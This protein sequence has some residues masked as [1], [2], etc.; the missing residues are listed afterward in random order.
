MKLFWIFIILL[1][2]GCGK[3]QKKGDGADL[4]EMSDKESEE[5]VDMTDEEAEAKEA[6]KASPAPE[7]E[8]DEEKGE[9]EA[10]APSGDITKITASPEYKALGSALES[11]DEMQLVR[12]ASKFLSKNPKDLVTLNAMAMHYF[13]R[14]KPDLGKLILAKALRLYP[15]SP[16]VHNN[17]GLVYLRE[18]KQLEAIGAFRKAQEL[19]VSHP[20]SAANL[21]SI[22]VK[23]KNYGAAVAYLQKAFRVLDKDLTVAN[24]F[25]VA[26]MGIKKFKDAEQIMEQAKASETNN[27]AVLL[28]Y[29]IL[30]CEHIKD[31]K[32]CLKGVNKIRFLSQDEVILGKAQRLAEKAEAIK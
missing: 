26:L 7:K 5:A 4:S 8:G 30:M 20:E 1:A 22:L 29:S 14:R 24:N 6:A 31:K 16:T 9:E 3:G 28:N 23:N 18:G 25:A 27:P 19:D 13:N 10:A 21:G 32:R 2:V 17:L 15:N 12:E 11:G